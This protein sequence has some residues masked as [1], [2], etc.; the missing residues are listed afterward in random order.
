M[1]WYAS[2][3]TIAQRL[4]NRRH[5]PETRATLLRFTFYSWHIHTFLVV[6][7]VL[8]VVI[9]SATSTFADDLFECVSLEG[10]RTVF[11]MVVGDTD[12]R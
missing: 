5:R 4:A 10:P 12:E 7:V 1:V 6:L 9:I 2:S 8:G 3:L 11:F